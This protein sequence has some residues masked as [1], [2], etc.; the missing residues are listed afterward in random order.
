MIPTASQ[1]LF[2]TRLQSCAGGGS[3]DSLLA[4]E[5]G[6]GNGPALRPG[7]P[8]PLDRIRARQF[9]RRF[10]PLRRGSPDSSGRI[11]RYTLNAVARHIG[12]RARHGVDMR[13]LLTASALDLCSGDCDAGRPDPRLHGLS[14]PSNGDARRQGVQPKE[15]LLEIRKCLHRRVGPAAL[16][17]MVESQFQVSLRCESGLTY[18]SGPSPPQGDGR[19]DKLDR[20]STAVCRVELA[21]RMAARWRRSQRRLLRHSN[22]CPS[23][24]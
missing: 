4:V 14:F 7:V 18:A 5:A 24:R 20:S 16:E 3:A 11:A 8:D 2:P 17:P 19:A 1:V 21:S 10:H 15:I 9:S 12:F 13:V 6:A 22:R 23:A